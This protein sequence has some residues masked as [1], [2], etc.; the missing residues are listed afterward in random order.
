MSW[1]CIVTIV[2]SISHLYTDKLQGLIDL[3]CGGLGGVNGVTLEDVM[4]FA[5]GCD[6]IPISGFEKQPCL[7]FNHTATLPTASTCVPILFLPVQVDGVAGFSEQ[8]RLAL[9]GSFG[10]GQV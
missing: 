10:F 3:F 9:L 4:V 7:K 5:T 1:S 8:M 6:H 2:F